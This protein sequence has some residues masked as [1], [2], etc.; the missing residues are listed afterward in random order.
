MTNF[1]EIENSCLS[2]NTIRNDFIFLHVNSYGLSFLTA[3]ELFEEYYKHLQDDID[4]ILE[5][6]AGL[7]KDTDSLAVV[8]FSLNRSS[9]SF[10]KIQDLDSEQSVFDTA[11]K[12]AAKVVDCLE[13]VRESLTSNGYLSM[14]DDMLGY[15]EK[16]A[17]FIAM[18]FCV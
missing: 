14:I 4:T 16:Q 18:R 1:N 11:Q 10:I 7:N 12:L 2:L 5:I 6:Y 13:N 17:R 8:P 15:W 9:G 3:H